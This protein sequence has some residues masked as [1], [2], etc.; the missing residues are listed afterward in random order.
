MSARRHRWRDFFRKTRISASL[1][2]KKDGNRSDRRDAD[3]GESPAIKTAPIAPCLLSNSVHLSFVAAHD[4]ET[5]TAA[6]S[7]R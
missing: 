6:V 4:A 3:D 5:Q 7:R 1:S 2:E